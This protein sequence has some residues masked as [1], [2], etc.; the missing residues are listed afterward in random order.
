MA[1]AKRIQAGSVSVNG[2]V[3]YA[4]DSPF[5]GFK[6]TGIGRQNGIEGCEQYTE[7]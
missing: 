5:G 2:G 1:V 4:P 7:T 3:W 6:A